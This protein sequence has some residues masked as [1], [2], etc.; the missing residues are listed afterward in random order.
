[1]TKGV[2]HAHGR[3]DPTRPRPATV[4]STVDGR[5]HLV[6]EQAMT[7][8]LL[9]GH[10]DYLAICGRVVVAA[11]MVVPPGRTCWECETARHRSIIVGTGRTRRRR[12][13]VVAWLL[14][15]RRRSVRAQSGA[16]GRV[17]AGTDR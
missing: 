1:M 3:P 7:V 14:R 6:G 5:D 15:R 4:T 8:G 16:A 2:C 12:R 10:G 13:G 9:A 17:S 11:P